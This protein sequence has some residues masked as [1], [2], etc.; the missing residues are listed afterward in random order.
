[1]TNFIEQFFLKDERRSTSQEI[2][3]PDLN[4]LIHFEL[5]LKW[6]Q[7]QKGNELIIVCPI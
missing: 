4:T 2:S 3:H 6:N 1:M 5:L 7:Q